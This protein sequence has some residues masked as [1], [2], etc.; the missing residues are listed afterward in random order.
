MILRWLIQLSSDGPKV[1]RHIYGV[2]VRMGKVHAL[3]GIEQGDLRF[4]LTT[5]SDSFYLG[6][7]AFGIFIY[8]FR[9]RLT[10]GN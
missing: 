4:Y 7:P 9:L 10:P 6:T 5:Q 1:N 2:D 8:H 3:G